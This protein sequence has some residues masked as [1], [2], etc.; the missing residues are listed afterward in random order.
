ML[1]LCVYVSGG[2][3]HAVYED[4]CITTWV[5]YGL[6]ILTHSL[7]WKKRSVFSQILHIW[8]LWADFIVS[9]IT[10]TLKFKGR[11]CVNNNPINM[12]L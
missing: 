1:S 9:D 10:I 7:L 2:L 3:E 11:L 5:V 12:E 4:V 8:L 6:V